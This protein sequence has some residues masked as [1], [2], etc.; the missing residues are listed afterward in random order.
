MWAGL[1]PPESSPGLQTTWS[2]LCPGRAIPLPASVSSSPVVLDQVH[3]K[4]TLTPLPLR[5]LYLQIQSHSEAPGL[6]RSTRIRGALETVNTASFHMPSAALGSGASLPL[7]TFLFYLKSSALPAART[8]EPS[9]LDLVPSLAQT[10]ALARPSCFPTL[11]YWR[12]T[13]T[14]P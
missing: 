13:C 6:D 14:V 1:V 5:R 3:P 9:R 8:Q 10:G 12:A 2:P 7:L 11:W 4:D